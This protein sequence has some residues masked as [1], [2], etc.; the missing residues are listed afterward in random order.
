MESLS[1]PSYTAF[2]S[3][4]CGQSCVNARKNQSQYLVRILEV[5][6]ASK[7]S[8]FNSLSP[9]LVRCW[10]DLKIRSVPPIPNVP[11][12][13]RGRNIVSHDFWWHLMN[14]TDYTYL[15]MSNIKPVPTSIMSNIILVHT[16]TVFRIVLLHRKN[17]TIYTVTFIILIS[18]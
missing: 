13:K 4:L 16:Q 12:F 7:N 14:S 5:I 2:S 9:F 15:T 10:T 18:L 3:L 6:I 1:E 8:M 11:L 17:R